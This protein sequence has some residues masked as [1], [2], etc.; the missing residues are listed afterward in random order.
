MPQELLYIRLVMMCPAF[1]QQRC[2]MNSLPVTFVACRR[3]LVSSLP[4]SSNNK[5]KTKQKNSADAL[6]IGFV[7]R[8]RFKAGPEEGAV[9]LHEEE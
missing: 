1:P 6:M 7:C 8:S 3:L 4:L 5:N 2:R 9:H